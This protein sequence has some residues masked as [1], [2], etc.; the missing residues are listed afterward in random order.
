MP[1]KRNRSTGTGGTNGNPMRG[2]SKVKS[3]GSAF[4]DHSVPVNSKSR[5][6]HTKTY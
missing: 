3:G 1:K 4:R 2:W 5:K 6:L